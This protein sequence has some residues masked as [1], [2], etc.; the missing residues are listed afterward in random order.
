[1]GVGRRR[2]EEEEEEEEGRGRRKER[3][4]GEEEEREE[5]GDGGRPH[6]RGG[7]GGGGKGGVGRRWF[8]GQLAARSGE[9]EEAE[10]EDEVMPLFAA[11]AEITGENPLLRPPLSPLSLPPPPQRGVVKGSFPVPPI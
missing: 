11:L 3:G 2:S 6:R 7:P 1:M 8:G 10:A 4:G 9:G 5:R